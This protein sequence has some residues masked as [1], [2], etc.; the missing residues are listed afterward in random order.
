MTNQFNSTKIKINNLIEK[1]LSSQYNKAIVKYPIAKNNQQPNKLNNIETVIKLKALFL[2]NN[3]PYNN[4]IKFNSKT[5]L[6]II[7]F[8]K[9]KRCGRI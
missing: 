8:N 4:I 6:V 1:L 9:F 3:H 2:I 7:R 5:F